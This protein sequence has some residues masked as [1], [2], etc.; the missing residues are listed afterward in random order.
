MTLI[1]ADLDLVPPDEWR[2]SITPW[3][4]RQGVPEPDLVFDLLSLEKEEAKTTPRDKR[5]DEQLD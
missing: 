1:D 4:L 5:A 3:L 2:A